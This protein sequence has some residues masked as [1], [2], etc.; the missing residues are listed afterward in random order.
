MKRKTVATFLL[1]F[2]FISLS[3][4]QNNEIL[5]LSDNTYEYINRL[6]KRGYL[7]SL[8]PSSLP[9]TYSEVLNTLIEVDVNTLSTS[10]RVWIEMIEGRVNKYD[11]KEELSSIEI[12]NELTVSDSKRLNTLEPLRSDLFVYPKVRFRGILGNDFFIG[13]IN[14]THSLYYDQD[15]D[16]I[17]VGDRL[18]F[19]PEDSYVGLNYSN[20][21]IYLGRYDHH[22]AVYNQSSM[23][24]SNNA[25]SFDK[26]ELGYTGKHFSLQSILGEL[27]NLSSNGTFEGKAIEEGSQRRYF[28]AHR[29]DWYPTKKWRLTYFESV[30]Y[31]GYNSSISPKFLNPLLAFSL[32]SSNNPINDD[33]NLLFGIST[34]WQMKKATFNVQFVLDDMH[35]LDRNEVTTF[36][37]SGTLNFS[38][39]ISNTDIGLEIESVAYQT[40]NAPEAEGRYLYLRRGIA[41]QNTDY[42]L[43]KLYSKIYLDKYVKGLSVTPSIAYYLQGEQIINQPIVR[44]ND[45]GSL[46]DI[47]LTGEVEKTLRS[48]LNIYYNPYPNFWFELNTGYN[49]VDNSMNISGNTKNRFSTIAKL[50]FRL[51]IY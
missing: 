45:D 20:F 38:E 29:I 36:S 19:R 51:Y 15:P 34:W 41:T 31:S 35:F 43:A 40:Y 24:L 42:I 30:I 33:V 46:I 12:D 18:Y 1:L 16:G 8:N 39:L 13:S 14:A 37:A 9:Y 11:Q 4:A 28:S 23:M 3:K 6:Q 22:W 44:T 49:K 25:R 17:D 10:E 27:D 47:I 2:S 21:D 26:I 5:L 32:L 50:G 48:G 7:L